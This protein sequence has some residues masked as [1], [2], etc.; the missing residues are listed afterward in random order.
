MK[1]CPTLHT[2]LIPNSR[3]IVLYSPKFIFKLALKQLFL[4]ETKHDMI[5]DDAMFSFDM[6][7]AIEWV[8]IFLAQ[9]E[10]CLFLPNNDITS[11]EM[12]IWFSENIFYK[13]S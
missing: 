12:M 13:A 10:Y 2:V 1:Y 3:I 11:I 8:R 6:L 4:W 9:E 5:S 7:N